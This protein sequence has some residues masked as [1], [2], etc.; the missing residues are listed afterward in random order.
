VQRHVG[1]RGNADFLC[2][3]KALFK[4]VAGYQW[5][6]R[7]VE[8]GLI[9]GLPFQETGG[10]RHRHALTVVPIENRR[11]EDIAVG[12]SLEVA[13]RVIRVPAK[14]TEVT[15]GVVAVAIAFP[16]D[17]EPRFPAFHRR[18]QQLALPRECRP[19]IEIVAG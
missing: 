6:R 3:L 1:R 19:R 2:E 17:D 11:A 14:T 12:E 10:S 8:I 15:E 13:G 18:P 9:H 4:V 16:V 5:Q 7:V